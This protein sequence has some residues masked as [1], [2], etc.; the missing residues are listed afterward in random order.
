MVLGEKKVPD[1]GSVRYAPGRWSPAFIENKA[2][3]DKVVVVLV[4]EIKTV[5]VFFGAG[6]ALVD[7]G[8]GCP[9]TL[10]TH[11]FNL[12]SVND[13]LRFV[14]GEFHIRHRLGV[15]LQDCHP[16]R[17]ELDDFPSLLG[18]TAFELD[19]SVGFGGLTRSKFIRPGT[20]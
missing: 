1:S 16:L 11:I 7:H 4:E 19:P 10:D 6:E 5:V 14:V 17:T 20:T 2:Q 13:V 18:V 12:I 3:G 15:T 8:G 9:L